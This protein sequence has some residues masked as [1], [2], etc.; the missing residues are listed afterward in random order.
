MKSEKKMTQ[1]QME[2]YFDTLLETEDVEDILERYDLT[3]LETLMF[4]WKNGLIQEDYYNES[5]VYE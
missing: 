1:D 2:E 3:P 4:L 5:E